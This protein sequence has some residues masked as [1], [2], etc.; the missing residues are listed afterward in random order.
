[1]WPVF[2]EM[3][4]PA[5]SAEQWDPG[6]GINMISVV[7]FPAKFR[8]AGKTLWITVGGQIEAAIRHI[9]TVIICV[10]TEYFPDRR[11]LN[12]A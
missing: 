2:S 1:M 5:A 11:R 4:K 3:R 8:H 7:N 9:V 12:D 6:S 10:M